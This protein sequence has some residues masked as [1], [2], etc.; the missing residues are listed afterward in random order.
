[1]ISQYNIWVVNRLS[2]LLCCWSFTKDIDSNLLALMRIMLL[3]ICVLLTM[4]Q[5]TWVE[6]G[7]SLWKK[8][9]IWATRL[10]L[11]T[12]KWFCSIILCWIYL[13]LYSAT[14]VYRYNQAVFS[15]ILTTISVFIV[16]HITDSLTTWISGGRWE[17][18][19]VNHH[20]ERRLNKQRLAKE[21]PAE[22]RTRDLR[23]GSLVR[24]L[25]RYACFLWKR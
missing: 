10:L 9:I 16:Y 19:Y 6:Y 17:T 24:F 20:R 3:V 11:T 1:M 5:H 13:S 7:I 18:M 15:F 12:W 14:H 8:P 4:Q 21:H 25:L 22:E 23:I 2:E